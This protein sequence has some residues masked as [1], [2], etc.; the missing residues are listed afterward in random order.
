VIASAAAGPLTPPAG[1]VAPTGKTLTQVEPRTEISATNTPGDASSVFRITQPGSYYLSG[2]VA[3]VLNKHG[4]V[5]AASRV[6]IDLNGFSVQGV[7]NSLTGVLVE[8][9]REG[10]VIRN[11][12]VTSWGQSG[13]SLFSATGGLLEGVTARHN[14]SDGIVAPSGGVVRGCVAADNGGDGIR[15]STAAVVESCSAF[16]NGEDGISAGDGVAILGCVARDNAVNGIT[17]GSNALV[18]ECL[19]TSNTGAGIAAQSAVTI[20][21][22]TCSLNFGSGISANSGCLIVGNHCVG[23]F[24]QFA[25]EGGIRTFGST[26]RIENNR[27]SGQGVGVG[28]RVENTGSLIIGNTTKS[29]ATHYVIAANNRYGPILDLTGTGT[30]AVNGQLAVSTVQ[31][32]D[33]RANFAH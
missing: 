5:I 20:K 31:S 11:G 28:I 22:C 9:S 8:G 25:D 12:F 4:I 26:N 2:H 18:S 6:S 21:D 7:A 15:I 16:E 14:A 33:P 30:A 29:F 24:A 13:V 17:T 3:G 32:A 19:S 23:N 1:P 10:I 27:L